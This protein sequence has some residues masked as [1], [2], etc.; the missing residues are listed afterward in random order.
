MESLSLRTPRLTIRSV[1]PDDWS[2][3]QVLALDWRNAPGPESDKWPTSESEVKK[4]AHYLASESNTYLCVLD[5]RD[6]TLMGLLALNGVD[7][8][9]ELDLGHVILS[10]YQ[11]DDHDREAL[12]AMIDYIFE[13]MGIGGIVTRNSNDATQ[14]M[15]LISLGFS[16]RNAGSPGELVLPRAQWRQTKRS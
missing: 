7:D 1:R 6:G 2:G 14:L 8:S 4:L 9:D 12:G 3:L 11:D 10:R 13:N 16:N 15:P 5:R